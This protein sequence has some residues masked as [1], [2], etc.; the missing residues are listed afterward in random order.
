M[1]DTK[2]LSGRIATARMALGYRPEKIVLSIEEATELEKD[3]VWRVA[4]LRGVRDIATTVLCHP[5]CDIKYGEWAGTE[6]FIR[7]PPKPVR[8]YHLNA[9]MT[10]D[11]LNC[12]NC[13]KLVLPNTILNNWF[14][15]L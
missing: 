15:W 9:K 10:T 11:V 1:F 3:E 13:G 7:I 12:P 6:V 5:G 2:E 8:C 14:D 4:C